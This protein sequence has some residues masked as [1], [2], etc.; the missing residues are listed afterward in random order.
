MTGLGE[1][2]KWV[3]EKEWEKYLFKEY[4][5]FN[6]KQ[7]KIWSLLNSKIPLLSQ[8]HK[9]YEVLHNNIKELEYLLSS[10]WRD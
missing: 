2:N 5:L 10:F 3:L 7:S 4:L 6:L 8:L 1:E 9:Y